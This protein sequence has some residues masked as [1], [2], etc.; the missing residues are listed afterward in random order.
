MLAG[1]TGDHS[2]IVIPV[3]TSVQDCT[4]S[5]FTAAIYLASYIIF[6]HIA[7]GHVLVQHIITHTC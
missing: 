5:I 2:I 3:K 1:P 7:S 4:T 6:G